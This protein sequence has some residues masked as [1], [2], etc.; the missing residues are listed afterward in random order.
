MAIRI[1]G[2]NIPDEKRIEVSLTYIHG[3]GRQ[4]S[5]EILNKTKIDP[6]T[7]ANKLSTE[8]VNKLR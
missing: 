5:K 2:V 4:R 7:R 6:D 1:S 8:E 3:I